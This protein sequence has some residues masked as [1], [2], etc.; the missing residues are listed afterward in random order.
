[1][2]KL[3]QRKDGRF[4][5][6]V[7]IGRD[8]DGR[9]KY[10]SIYG[11]TQKEVRA[12]ERELR[13]KLERGLDVSAAPDTFGGWAE[14]WKVIKEP[15]VAAGTYKMY[16]SALEHLATIWDTPIEKV[17]KADIQAVIASV[18]K[19]NPN[20]KKPAS[21][22]VLKVIR[23][24]ARQV[25]QL[26]IDSRVMD[27]NA[28]ATVKTSGQG[29]KA[30]EKRRAL[31][32]EE[33]GWIINTH[34]RAQTAAM[35]LL[36]TGLRRGELLPLLWSDFDFQNNSVQVVKS[37]EMIRGRPVLKEG[38]KTENATRVV[39]FP[40]ILGDY[41]QALPR[42]S[43]LLVPGADG[44][45][46]T[47]TAWKRMWD[48]YLQELNLKYGDFSSVPFGK[49]GK[50]RKSKFESK[51]NPHGVPMVIPRFTAHWL[52][53]TFATMMYLAGVDVLTAKEQLGHADIKTTLDLYTHLDAIYKQKSI[54]KLE[55]YLSGKT[56][57]R[58]SQIR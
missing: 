28:A 33:Q 24:T 5:T 49:D 39:F 36:F 45:M 48:S 27:Y 29:A 1:M 14:R 37:V 12:K 55:N 3:T 11:K 26:A 35:L 23:I 7:L 16:L 31:T 34:H 40:K 42:N 52:R 2:G 10:K 9:K 57:Q 20:T 8:Q 13:Q 38:G 15:S 41:L 32:E 6:Q 54:D 53:H 30:K 19:R 47:A 21:E 4:C 17:R 51:H 22:A 56:S 18:A 25:L 58:T 44:G 46:M 50:P 43:L